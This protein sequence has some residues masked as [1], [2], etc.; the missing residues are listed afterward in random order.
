MVTG[1]RQWQDHN[2]LMLIT[3][4][5]WGLAHIFFWAKTAQCLNKSG[6]LQARKKVEVT[7]GYAATK[8]LSGAKKKNLADVGLKNNSSLTTTYAT[9]GKSVWDSSKPTYSLL[10]RVYDNL[11]GEKKSNFVIHVG[12]R[13]G[14][15]IWASGSYNNRLVSG[16]CSLL[17]QNTCFK[18]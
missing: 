9:F 2:W 12:T 10:K 6:V 7:V 15:L 5:P 14:L 4:L 11:K 18:F 8:I 13:F 17:H 3:L 16:I 1:K